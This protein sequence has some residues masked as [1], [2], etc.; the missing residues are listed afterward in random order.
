MDYLSLLPP[1]VT[2]I[3]AIWTKH[4]IISLFFGIWLGS[5]ILSGWN[6]I[7]GFFGIFSKYLIPSVGTPW[8]ATVLI[9]GAAFGGLLAILQKN[10]GANA[11]GRIFEKHSSTRRKAELYTFFFGI[12][13]FLDDYFNCL[14]LGTV[15]RPICDKVKVAREKLAFIVDSTAAP[16]CLLVP[17]S[18]W[19]VYVVGL[20]EKEL[21][22]SS[23]NSL[24]I[25][26]K[27]I[28]LNF[29]SIIT[30]V[31]TFIII[32]SRWS[33]GPMKKSEIESLEIKQKECEDKDCT[34]K[35]NLSS[36]LIP[37]VTLLTILP[38]MLLYTG[39]YWNSE[40]SLL[41]AIGSSQGA[42]SILISAITAGIVA[43]FLGIV[44]GHFN[45]IKGVDY[46]LQGM[47]N[48]YMTALILIFAWSIGQLI[49]ELGTATYLSSFIS[50]NFNVN[51]IPSILF[52]IACGISFT[53]GTSYGTFA[54]LIPFAI[55]MAIQFGIPVEYCVA[56]V[57][58]GGIFGD[59]SSPI[60]D[61]T[62]LA[63]SSSDC[64]LI[65]HFSTQLPYALLFAFATG[66]GFL[67]LGFFQNILVSLGSAI[68]IFIVCGFLCQKFYGEKS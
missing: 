19:V 56:A 67:I 36:F 47:K 21:Q 20:I 2:I 26:L 51:F 33:F 9:Y 53:T 46:Y 3:L 31:G 8:N 48:M 1:L 45:L 6:P 59:H 61:T 10:G 13:I 63:A 38:L 23:Q 58:S 52:L 30:L 32:M 12:F 66:I 64:D 39:G 68:I 5:T 17:V 41:D 54:I 14:T 50:E 15:M 34:E 49:K 37:I 24:S 60:S 18:T 11:F 4:I 35:S 43:I 7:L 28:P 62:I 57:L 65:E 29:Y 40:K 55:P 16:V 44:Q 27:T 22:G 25:Y 42:F